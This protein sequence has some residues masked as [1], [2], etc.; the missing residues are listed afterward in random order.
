[1]T[2]RK[3]ILFAL[4]NIEQYLIFYFQPDLRQ[5]RPVQELKIVAKDP[6]IPQNGVIVQ[7]H[8]GTEYKSV[9]YIR[10]VIYKL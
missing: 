7:S 5:S 3:S 2:R 1:M 10:I 9:R 4:K 8:A 6:G